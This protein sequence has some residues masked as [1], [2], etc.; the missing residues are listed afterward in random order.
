M[1]PKDSAQEGEKEIQQSS[2]TV[3]DLGEDRTRSK[4]AKKVVFPGNK[5]VKHVIAGGVAGAVSRTCVS[6][7][8]RVKILLQVSL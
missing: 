3:Q 6:P 1:V 4:A 8:E 5:Q 2:V 7:L